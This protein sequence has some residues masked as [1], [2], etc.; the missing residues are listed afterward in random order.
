METRWGRTFET[1]IRRINQITLSL[2][3]GYFIGSIFLIALA[4]INPTRKKNKIILTGC[5]TFCLLIPLVVMMIIHI[6]EYRIF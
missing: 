3:L 1:A 2:I 5:S 4:F 6:K